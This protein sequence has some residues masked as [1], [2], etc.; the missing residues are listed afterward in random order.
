MAEDLSARCHHQSPCVKLVAFQSVDSGRKFLACAEKVRPSFVVTNH[1]LDVIQ[2]LSRSQAIHT[3]PSTK[4]ILIQCHSLYLVSKNVAISLVVP[5]ENYLAPLQQFVQPTL[6]H[7]SEQPSSK[8]LNLYGTK[9]LG[10]GATRCSGVRVLDFFCTASASQCRAL[11]R[12]VA[13]VVFTPVLAY[14]VDGFSAIS[15]MLL[16][17]CMYTPV[18]INLLPS[19]HC[20]YAVEVIFS[21]LIKCRVVVVNYSF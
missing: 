8:I 4:H 5:L 2:I 11:V 1:L 14:M 13:I 20:R 7:T 10:I 9:E 3:T 19:K 18:S 15:S 16:N 17:L 21:F 6:V 12:D